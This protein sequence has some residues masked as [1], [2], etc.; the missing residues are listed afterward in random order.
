ME[1]IELLFEHSKG[2]VEALVEMC[3]KNVFNQDANTMCR[4]I[5]ETLGFFCSIGKVYHQE[6]D[7]SQYMDYNL[8]L[9][10]ELRYT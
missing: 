10:S 7:Y 8:N 3:G 2:L 9:Q 4:Y 5:A 1:A 6:Y